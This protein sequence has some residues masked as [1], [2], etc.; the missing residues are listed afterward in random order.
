LSLLY[1]KHWYAVYSKPQKEEF[2]KRQLQLK[3]IEVFLP[4][5]ILPECARRPRRIVPLFPSYLFVRIDSVTEECFYVMWSPGVKRL[6]CFNGVPAAIDDEIINFLMNHSDA[7]GQIAASSNLRPGQRVR[8]NGGP[9]DGLVGLIEEPPNA[10]GRVKVLMQLL[11][12]EV[13]TEV[14]IR[15]LEGNWVM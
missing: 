3:G 7:N 9:L 10:R 12:R 2:A 14:P 4:K 8:I 11:N 1:N 13:H 6:V 5:L 15:Y